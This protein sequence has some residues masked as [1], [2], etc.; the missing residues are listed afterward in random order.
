MAAEDLV[1]SHPFAFKKDSTLGPASITTATSL[2]VHG[3]ERWEGC[4][5]IIFPR[6]HCPKDQREYLDGNDV[7][8][9][10]VAQGRSPTYLSLILGTPKLGVG[11][12]PP[13]WQPAGRV[14]T[15]RSANSTGDNSRIPL[16]Y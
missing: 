6:P 2:A 4:A 7:G 11:G 10:K 16:L 5:I 9:I 1:Q 14:I 3:A 15:D 12:P 13:A 8:L